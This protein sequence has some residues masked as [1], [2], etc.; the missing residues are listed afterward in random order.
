MEESNARS[1]FKRICVFCG[2]NSGRRKVFSDA[3]L[4][5]GNELVKR[6][7]DLV[8]GGGSV[9]LM[10]LISQTVYD[11]GCHVLGVIPKALM[12]L[13][14]SGPTVGEVRTVTDMHERKASMAQEA[15]AFIAL[16]GGYGT[17]E[18]LL[19]IITWAQ[20]GIHM[21]PVGLLNVDGYYNSLLALF[22][23][24]VEEGFIK[25]CAR[26]IVVSAPTAKELVVKMEQYTPS[27]E[28]VAS[29]E[30]WQMEQLDNSQAK[31]TQVP[32][33]MVLQY[34]GFIGF[35]R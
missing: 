6:K 10:G 34:R 1:K 11:G 23:N 16:P 30:S 32:G 3:A 22:D 29:H 31:K 12:P 17:M 15:D 27:H 2:S 7:I 24:G 5:L 9:G 20:L 18:E 28:H 25:P 33:E 4:E 19:E 13:E 35:G 26:H 21:K 14:I 8:Y